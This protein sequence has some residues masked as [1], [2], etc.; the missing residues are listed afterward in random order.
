MTFDDLKLKYKYINNGLESKFIV[1]INDFR[2][3]TVQ[4]DCLND[5]PKELAKSFEVMF[6]YKIRKGDIEKI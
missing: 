1:Y 2:G 3:V 6:D 4:V 5:A